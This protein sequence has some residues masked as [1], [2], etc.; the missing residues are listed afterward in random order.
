MKASDY[1]AT[2][3]AATALGAA[4]IAYSAYGATSA[5]Q[6]SETAAPQPERKVSGSR[7]T[8]V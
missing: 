1:V 2:A 3:A 6:K 8:K 5:A 4:Q 7:W